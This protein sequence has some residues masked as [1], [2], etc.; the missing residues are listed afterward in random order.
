M[1]ERL[2]GRQGKGERFKVKMVL[3]LNCCGVQVGHRDIGWQKQWVCISASRSASCS[4]NEHSAE[5]VR[6]K[7]A[8]EKWTKKAWR[9][10]QK[11][12]STDSVTIDL[13]VELHD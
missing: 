3:N 7:H 2:G 11:I 13:E 6:R 12:E 9:R 5:V 1:G 8:E 4:L 10:T